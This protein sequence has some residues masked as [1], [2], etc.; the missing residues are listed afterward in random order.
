M[1][2]GKRGGQQ[3]KIYTTDITQK[4]VHSCQRKDESRT[5]GEA[6]E[7]YM[8][9]KKQDCR[10]MRFDCHRRPKR[11]Q[12]RSKQRNIDMRSKNKTV[13]GKEEI[14]SRLNEIKLKKH[15]GT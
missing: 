1:T 14:R 8:S 2:L 3:G 10:A 9:G 15:A 11:K 4:G 7:K 5:N 13:K 12:T 6:L